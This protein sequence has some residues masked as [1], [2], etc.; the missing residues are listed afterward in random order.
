MVEEFIRSLNSSQI[1]TAAPD[2]LAACK[3]AQLAFGGHSGRP[4]DPITEIELTQRSAVM[5]AIRAAIRRA[6]SP[7][8]A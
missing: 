6:E 5:V 4:D 7:S 3:A 8:C 1:N 2:L